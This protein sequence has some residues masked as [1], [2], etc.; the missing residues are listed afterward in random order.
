M[1]TSSQLY[2]SF[3]GFYQNSV[4]SSP[5]LDEVSMSHSVGYNCKMIGEERTGKRLM[6]YCDVLSQDSY[7]GHE[8][9]NAK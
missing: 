1:P 7:G 4:G 6:I 2:L 3:R 5:L 8:E 9:K